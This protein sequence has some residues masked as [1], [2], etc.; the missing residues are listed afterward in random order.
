MNQPNKNH[1]K[2]PSFILAVD[3]APIKKIVTANVVDSKPMWWLKDLGGEHVWEA[4]EEQPNTERI[5]AH[6]S[7]RQRQLLENDASFLQIL[8]YTLIGYRN[9]LGE[10]HMTTYYRKKGHGEERLEGNMSFGW[11]GHVEIEDLAWRENGDLDFDQ[12]VFQNL[13]RELGEECIFIDT[14][15]GEEVSVH[16]LV[17]SL[18]ALVAQ[19][20]I[21]DERN[22][23]GKHHL[24]LVN[25][26]VLPGYIKLVKR[27][28]EHLQGEVMSVDQL[29]AAIASFEPW[30]EIIIN[31][32]YANQAGAQQALH[33]WR[34]AHKAADYH[35]LAVAAGQEEPLL[36]THATT[37]QEAV[38]NEGIL[39]DGGQNIVLSK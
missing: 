3:A 13:V 23:V 21:L 25:L 4:A 22:D 34:E 18:N 6:L 19:G 9:A 15:T 28:K 12:T 7:I 14:R 5:N 27:E 29:L 1:I 36:G 17:P 10:V 37:V 11:G 2:Y 38:I 31:S 35:K 16:D 32:H 33:E 8:P 30:S 26:L 20:F 24:A 39:K